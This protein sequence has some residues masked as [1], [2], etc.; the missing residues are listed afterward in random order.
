MNRKTLCRNVDSNERLQKLMAQRVSGATDAVYLPGDEVV[1][2]EKDKSRRSGPAKV[3]NVVGNKVR[4][5]FGGFERT[6]PSIDVAHFKDEKTIVKTNEADGNKEQASQT[7]D[8]EADEDWHSKEDLPEGWMLQNNKNIR[9]KLH[10][11]I[12]FSVKG[13]L[14]AGRVT[15]VGK[16][17]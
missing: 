15:R 6:V 16:T 1:F 2:K 13:F 14:R 12:E 7:S 4:M 10:D 9:P 11:N 17:T 8:V 3:T 5:I